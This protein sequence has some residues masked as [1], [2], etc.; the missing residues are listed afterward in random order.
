M[1]FIP[2]SLKSLQP[3]MMICP[4]RSEKS[5]MGV[6]LKSQSTS[7]YYD[8]PETRNHSLR[9][10]SSQCHDLSCRR[11]GGSAVGNINVTAVAFAALS[12]CDKCTA[13]SSP[14]IPNGIENGEISLHA[15]IASRFR[16][17]ESF[18]AWSSADAFSKQ[19]RKRTVRKSYTFPCS[20]S[21]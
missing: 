10:K 14:G 9:S 11:D 16:S 19:S 17:Q 1:A 21:S 18:T 12:H 2:H 5:S 7:I 4:G 8:I 20:N 6:P 15:K 3:G 13:F